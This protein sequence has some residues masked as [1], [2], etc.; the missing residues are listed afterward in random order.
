[1][2]AQVNTLGWLSV[3][4]CSSDLYV[5]VLCLEF[6]ETPQVGLLLVHF[7]VLL[8]LPSL[9]CVFL[10]GVASGTLWR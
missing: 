10:M 3:Q 6:E 2:T 8:T 1:M 7:S 4:S 5:L 9:H